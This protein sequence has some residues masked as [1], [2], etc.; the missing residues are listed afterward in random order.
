MER[1]R[2][3]ENFSKGFT[4]L[5][6][7]IGNILPLLDLT[8]REYRVIL[9][10]IR[11]TYG[12]N[13]RWAKL[14]QADLQTVNITPNHAKE[15]NESLLD[16]KVIVKNEN[17]KEFR[18]NEEYLTSSKV[19]EEITYQLERLQTLVGRHLDSQTSLKSNKSIPNSGSKEFP[20]TED[21]SSQIGNN[22]GLPNQEVL[23]T[24]SGYFD[25][26]KDILNKRKYKD[27]KDRDSYKRLRQNINPDAFFPNNETEFEMFESFKLIDGANPDSF[28]FYIWALQGGLPASKFR[29]FREDI[30]RTRKIKNK[31]AVFV[32]KVKEYFREAKDA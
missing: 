12:C 4:Q 24:N 9:L 17:K 14:K 7:K 20:N 8:E 16:K 32:T 30:L 1:C 19:T 3:M 13:R 11:L 31:G 5:P 10:I 28:S 21:T 15:V 18:L 27:I 26:S 25:A 22:E 6:H 29:E 2:S 23:A